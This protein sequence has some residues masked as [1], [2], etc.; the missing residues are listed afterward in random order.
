MLKKA[1]LEIKDIALFEVKLVTRDTPWAGL[2]DTLCSEAFSAVSKVCEKVLGL[3]P[4]NTNKLGGAV[5]LG[6]SLFLLSAQLL[7]DQI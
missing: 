4:A 6:V 1:Q 7:K 3:D 5:S 2:A